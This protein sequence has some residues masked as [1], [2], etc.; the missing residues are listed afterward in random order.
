MYIW[1]LPLIHFA[2]LL[3][4]VAVVV[5]WELLACCYRRS[6]GTVARGL[7]LG[8]GTAAL[9]LSPGLV[10][11]I[12]DP[13]LREFASRGIYT[14]YGAIFYAGPAVLA[15]CLFAWSR[16]TIP[17]TAPRVV[18]ARLVFWFTAGI[19][20]TANLANWCSPGWCEFFG[21]PLSILLVERRDRDP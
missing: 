2:S 17:T 16:S 10:H 7:L 13:E 15:M 4:L 12:V 5:V 1:R 6:S 19:L 11:V 3:T 20:T 21:F 18:R 14:H 8:A 9:L